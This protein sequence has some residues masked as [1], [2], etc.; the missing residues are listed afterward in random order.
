M[1]TPGDVLR[2]MPRSGRYLAGAVVVAAALVAAFAVE[3]AGQAQPT[4]SGAT[5][6]R[7]AAVAPAGADPN[8]YPFGKPNAAPDY[9]VPPPPQDPG[10]VATIGTK[11]TQRIYGANAYQEAVSVTQH[12][13]PA[14]LPENAPNENNNVPDRPWG[15]TLITPDDPLSAMTAVPLIHFPNDAPILYVSKTGIPQVTL[16]EIKRLG[17]TGISRFKNIDAFLVGAAAN[18]A[19]ENQ[20]KAIGV[21]YTTVTAPNIPQLADNVDKLYGSIQNPDTGVP[22]MNTSGSTGGNGM[23]DVMIGSTSAWQYALPSTHWVSH[24]PTALLWVDQNSIPGPTIDALKRRMGRAMIYVWGGPNQVSASVVKQLNQ[25]GSVSRITND[26]AVAFN[27]TPTDTPEATSIA[28]AKMW[29]P[30]G[31]MGWNISGP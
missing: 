12:I 27:A 2:S 26:D 16:D 3:T 22:Q 15:L 7:P 23:L 18:S 10:L 19:V 20:L 25:Y 11:T 9:Q 21:T 1:K 6:Q 17:D 29:D 24:M 8:L 13:W 4:A 28:F 5:V 14:A 30:A 31:M